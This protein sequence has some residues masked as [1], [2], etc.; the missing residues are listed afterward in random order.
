MGTL[1]PHHHRHHRFSVLQS[2]STQNHRVE[3]L[4]VE[5]NQRVNYPIKKILLSLEENGTID[6]S[7]SVTKFCVSYCTINVLAPA[8][9]I[10]RTTIVCIPG[11]NGGIPN[12]LATT[13]S[14]IASI[15]QSQIP[16]TCQA[17]NLFTSSGGHL[18]LL[19]RRPT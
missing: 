8:L 5:I 2:T 6:L 13:R 18:T 15:P 1:Q 14:N 4:W 3:R 12:V 19:W 16:T 17:I 7:C 11:S 9:R 10:S